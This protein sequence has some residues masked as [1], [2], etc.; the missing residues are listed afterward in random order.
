MRTRI[1]AADD[2]ISTE[3]SGES[4]IL[5]LEDGVYFGLNEVGSRIWS[6]AAQPVRVADICSAIE[7]E[8]DVHPETCRRDVLRL[9]GE[10]ADHDLVRVVE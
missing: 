2:A 6:L 7:E 3:V 4:V 10:L 9:L 1:A 8:Y 5:H